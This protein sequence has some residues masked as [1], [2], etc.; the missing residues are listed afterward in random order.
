MLESHNGAQPPGGVMKLLSSIHKTL[1]LTV[2][3]YPLVTIEPLSA[4]DQELQE[5]LQRMEQLLQQQQ[6][7]L[8]AQRRELAE[9]RELIRQLQESHR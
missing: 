7:E 6:E 1:F 9:Q 5:T 4:D 2:L 8:E 3:A